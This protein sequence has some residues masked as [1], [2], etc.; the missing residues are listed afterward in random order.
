MVPGERPNRTHPQELEGLEASQGHQSV[1]LD[2]NLHV[3]C[4]TRTPGQVGKCTKA[5]SYASR[6][7]KFVSRFSTRDSRFP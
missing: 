3:A 2:V 5:Y 1:V 7:R 6:I 4:A